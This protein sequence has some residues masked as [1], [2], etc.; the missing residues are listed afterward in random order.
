MP[1]QVIHHYYHPATIDFVSVQTGIG[2]VPDSAQLDF[3]TSSEATIQWITALYGQ[4]SHKPVVNLEGVYDEAY[5]YRSGPDR[6]DMARR[7]AYLS[8]FSGACGYTSS[9]YGVWSWGKRLGWGIRTDAVPLKEAI[10]RPYATYLQHLSRF[11]AGIDWWRLEPCHELIKNQP[12]DWARKMVLAK[13][14]D[15][16]LA[17]TYLPDNDRIVVD[18]S[19]FPQ[20]MNAVWFDPVQDLWLRSSN[21]VGRSPRTVFGRPQNLKDALLV[22]TKADSMIP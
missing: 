18:M 11:L 5:Q 6:I 7:A 4:R 17:V 2:P 20:A 13:T 8:F 3:A 22:L 10:A 9:T 14:P 1:S 21:H 15:S 12:T 16:D 19:A